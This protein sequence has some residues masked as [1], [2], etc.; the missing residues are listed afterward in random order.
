LLLDKVT[1]LK[2]KDMEEISLKRDTIEQ[3][4]DYTRYFRFE[5]EISITKL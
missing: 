4:V 5:L 2:I 1:V 3:Y